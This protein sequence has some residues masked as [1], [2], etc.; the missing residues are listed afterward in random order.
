MILLRIFLTIVI[1]SQVVAC[2]RHSPTEIKVSTLWQDKALLCKQ[3]FIV[4]DSENW[5]IDQLHFFLSDVQ[6]QWQ[7]GQ[8]QSLSLAENKFQNSGVVLIGGHCQQN[9]QAEQQSNW[10]INL[11][12]NIDVS[13]VKALTFTLGVPFEQNHLNPL[14]QKSPLNL[15]DMFWVWQTGHKFLRAE[16]SSSNSSWLFHLGSTACS[17]VS[18]LRM[19]KQACLRPNRIR[20]QLPMSNISNDKQLNINFHLDKLLT[21][22]QLSTAKACQSNA[23]NSTCQQLFKNLALLAD[24]QVSEQEVFS[25][26]YSKK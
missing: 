13:K 11:L 9:T 8:W 12:E 17:A 6:V 22:V 21:N 10:Q 2:Q 1:M 18:S 7:N 23:E 5:V 16:L 26:S 19:P 20:Y 4:Q 25:L 3:D 24:T 14:K 15:P